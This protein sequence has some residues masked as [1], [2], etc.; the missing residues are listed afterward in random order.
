M[1][2]LQLIPRSISHAC[3]V[4]YMQSFTQSSHV[5]LQAIK[6]L[7]ADYPGGALWLH[8]RQEV[9]LPDHIVGSL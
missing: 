2:H 9:S 7:V 6:L 3:S 1:S 5:Q 8:K 4:S